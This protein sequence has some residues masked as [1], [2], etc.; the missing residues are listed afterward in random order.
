MQRVHER[1][2]DR[3]VQDCRREW[4]V[5]RLKSLAGT[6][7]SRSDPLR[8]RGTDRTRKACSC[9][10]GRNVSGKLMQDEGSQYGDP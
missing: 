6:R 5:P 8:N 3:L 7:S 2:A 4:Q 10:L 9:E 1:L